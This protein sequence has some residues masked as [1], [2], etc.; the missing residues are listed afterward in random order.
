MAKR[1]RHDPDLCAPLGTTDAPGIAFAEINAAE[2]EETLQLRLDGFEGP[3][4]LLLALAREQ[5]VDL[6]KISVRQLADQFLAFIQRAR[7]LRIELAAEYLVMAAWLAYLKSRLLLP[8]PPDD[9]EE[10]SAEA[11]AS[12]LA[13]QLQRLEAM[14]HAAAAL[15]DRPLR[16]R[17][18]FPRG[19]PDQVVVERS[20]VFDC[21]LLDLLKAYA[22]HRRRA[23]TSTFTIEQTALHSLEDALERLAERLG[24]MPD[25]ASLWQFLPAGGPDPL[26]TRSAIASTLAAGLQ[27]AKSGAVELHQDRPFAPIYIRRRPP[28][29]EV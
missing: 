6:A 7:H 29:E 9:E 21:S 16:G 10:P 12:A 18:V 26:L 23:E 15:F 3:I 22:D 27:M 19:N 24:C 17:D 13:F 20:S 28:V 14:R 25:W 4:D 2:R 8:T 5:K 11:L 1:R